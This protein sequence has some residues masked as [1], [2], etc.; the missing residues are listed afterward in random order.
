MDFDPLAFSDPFDVSSENIRNYC[1]GGFCPIDL[2]QVVANRFKIIHKLGFGGFST[3]WLARDQEKHRYIALKIVLADE[4]DTYESASGICDMLRSNPELFVPELERFTIKSCNGSHLCQ[5]FPVLGPSLSQ[6]AD[7]GRR[8]F[9][10]VARKFAKQTA[11]A[12]AVM[13]SSGLCHGGK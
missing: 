8:L 12:M 1:L 9:P 13:H 6:M 3:V 7:Y 5:V 4:S 11:E 10:P 2:G